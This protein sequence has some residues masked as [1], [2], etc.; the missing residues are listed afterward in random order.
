MV[1]NK[2]GVKWKLIGEGD[3]KKPKVGQNVSIHYD[4]WF[5]EGTTTSNF[6]YDK[7]EYV[8]VLHDCT[9]DEQDPFHGPVDFVI[10]ER[11]PDDDQYKKGHSIAGLDEVL[12]DMKVGEKRQVHIPS[13]LAYGKL[14]GSSFHT[15]H[16]YRTPPN[17]PLE[18]EIEIV[19][20]GDKK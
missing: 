9:H 19:N 3:G 13:K 16:G 10:G 20:I 18:M 17:C 12:L 6:D 2:S 5:G 14:G 1:E 7:N 4:I 11:T 8:D 15:F